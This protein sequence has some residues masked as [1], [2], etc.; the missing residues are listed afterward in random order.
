MPDVM[1]G[2]ART[3]DAALLLLALA[4]YGRSA[5]AQGGHEVDKA[6]AAGR[7]SVQPPGQI[8]TSGLDQPGRNPGSGMSGTTGT[9]GSSSQATAGP[10]E[11]GTVETQANQPVTPSETTLPA[12]PPPTP[13]PT[14]YT[15]WKNAIVSRGIQHPVATCAILAGLSIL[16]SVGIGLVFFRRL[17]G[18]RQANKRQ[19]EELRQLKTDLDE[20]QVPRTEA[21][22]TAQALPRSPSQKPRN[23]PAT[24]TPRGESLRDV[25]LRERA[26]DAIRQKNASGGRDEGVIRAQESPAPE[27]ESTSLAPPPEPGRSAHSLSAEVPVE[28]APVAT[29]PEWRVRT[30]H[31][32]R[33]YNAARA[34]E[35]GDWFHEQY[36]CTG[37]SC[38]N[39]T[40]LR[41]NPAAELRFEASGYGMFL[42]VMQEG[43]GFLLPSFDRDYLAARSSFEGVFNYPSTSAGP[44]ALMREARIVRRGELWLLQEPGEMTLG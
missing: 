1:R 39:L 6:K 38:Q 37:L 25:S 17:R 36:P 3:A 41:M 13:A 20:L 8:P 2:K 5:P 30:G 14:G 31:V 23:K 27:V 22:H 15:S 18:L 34:H 40:D 16:V 4:M 9:A 19:Q 43:Q 11:G 42:G 26:S 7:S 33:D 21:P 44:F 32:L 35:G 28:A 12:A 10:T 24:N 29:Q